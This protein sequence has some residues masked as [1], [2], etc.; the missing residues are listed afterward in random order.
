L[1]G[2]V[3]LVDPIKEFNMQ[4]DAPAEKEEDLFS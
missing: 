1:A 2:A 4:I 3:F